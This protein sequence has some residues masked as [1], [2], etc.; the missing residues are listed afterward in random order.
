LTDQTITIPEYPIEIIRKECINKNIPVFLFHHGAGGGLHSEFS[1]PNI[2]DYENYQVLACNKNEIKP[3]QFNRTVIGDFSSSYTY[4]KFLNKLNFENINFLTDRKHKIAFYIGGLM[5]A[6]TSTTAWRVQE[7]II[8]DLSERDDVA[9]ILK[10]H[11]RESKNIDL[12]M[13][14][15]FSNL[16]IV[17]SETD[18]SRVSKWADVC[19][20]N[21]H[22][23]VIFEPMILG[24]KVVAIKGKRIP[25]ENN[26]KSPLVDSSVN[27]ITQSFEFKLESLKKAD[28]YDSVTN[29][30]A[31]GGNGEVD[32]AALLSKIIQDL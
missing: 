9:M 12:R 13:L 27:Y 11:P 20:I 29:E 16:K 6:L 17:S 15:S 26:K 31:W 8:I 24:K 30:I 5:G 25:S 23:S 21:D 4:V 32:L 28:P 7:E 14:K 1:Y 2:Q 3:G 18:R 19:I 22:S 10:L